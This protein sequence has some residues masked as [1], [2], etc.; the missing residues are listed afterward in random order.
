[1]SSFIYLLQLTEKYAELYVHVLALYCICV[2]LCVFV[3]VYVILLLKI[4]VTINRNVIQTDIFDVS[5]CVNILSLCNLSGY[6]KYNTIRADPALCFVERVG[7][8]DEKA[9]AAEQRGNDFMDG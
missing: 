7:R 9:I 8:P 6:E 1:M 4:L 5:L 3:C 2:C